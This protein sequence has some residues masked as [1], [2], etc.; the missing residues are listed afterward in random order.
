[1]CGNIAPR[2]PSMK[3]IYIIAEKIQHADELKSTNGFN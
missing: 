1:M 2:G 3:H